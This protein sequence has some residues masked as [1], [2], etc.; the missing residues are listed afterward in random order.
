MA[1]KCV[2]TLQ[3]GEKKEKVRHQNPERTHTHT[4]QNTQGI[5]PTTFLL[6]DYSTAQCDV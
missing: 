4:G 5:E 1:S 3:E 2:E 6:R